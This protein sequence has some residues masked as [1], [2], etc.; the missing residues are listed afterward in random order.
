V[1]DERLSSPG[2][3]LALLGHLARQRLFDAYAAYGLAPRQFRVLGLLHDHGAVSQRDLGA[4]MA[5]DPS[6]LVTLLNPMEDDGLISRD[7]D[8]ADRR[9]H[10]VTLT[11]RGRQL[12]AE[13][14]RAQHEVDD[15]LFDALGQRE[16]EQ[17]LATL[18]RL[19]E[20]LLDVGSCTDAAS[21]PAE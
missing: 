6:V 11:P 21:T 14:S 16:R 20:R 13:A 15:G 5:T 2:L 9:R 1:L 4:T 18:T 17:L 19:R 7:R 3:L 12:H 10:L 8:P